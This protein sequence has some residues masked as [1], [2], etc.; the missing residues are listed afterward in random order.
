[1]DGNGRTSRLLQNFEL[2]KAGFPPIVIKKERRLEYYKA[3][4]KA[5]TTGETEDFIKFSAEC[6]NESLNL[7][8]ETIKKGNNYKELEFTKEYQKIKNIQ[9]EN[10]SLPAPY[11]S[12]R[13]MAVG[14]AFNG[15]KQSDSLA[16]DQVAV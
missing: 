7:Y 4:D 11:K 12:L 16:M 14:S 5:H 13:K 10:S 15:R 2:M 8:L 6:L 3:L 1:M 9:R